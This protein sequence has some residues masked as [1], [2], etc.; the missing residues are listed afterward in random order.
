MSGIVLNRLHT[1][2]MITVPIIDRIIKTMHVHKHANAAGIESVVELAILLA[3][4][5]ATI[6]TMLHRK[7]TYIMC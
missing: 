6:N 2:L 1:L 3:A 4:T 5:H 7:N